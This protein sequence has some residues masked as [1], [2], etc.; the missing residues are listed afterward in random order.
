MNTAILSFVVTKNC[1]MLSLTTNKAIMLIL[2]LDLVVNQAVRFLDVYVCGA[3]RVR[4][5]QPAERAERVR[6]G[7]EQRDRYD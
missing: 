5:A 1:K 3:K 4:W 2:I 6:S 7:A